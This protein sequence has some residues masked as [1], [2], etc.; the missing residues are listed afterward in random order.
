MPVLANERIKIPVIFEPKD[1][2][3]LL[4][5]RW[6]LEKRDGKPITMSEAIRIAVR[7]SAEDK[8]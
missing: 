3:A 7:E 1:R 8:D 2:A 6:K 5:L 4:R